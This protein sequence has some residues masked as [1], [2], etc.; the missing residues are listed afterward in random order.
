[1]VSLCHWFLCYLFL[2]PTT[3]EEASPGGG[4]LQEGRGLCALTVILN[5]RRNGHQPVVLIVGSSICEEENRTAPRMSGGGV[6]ARD[7]KKILGV[8]ALART[9]K[10]QESFKH[11][12]LVIS[13]EWVFERWLNKGRMEA[14][15]I[16]LFFFFFSKSKLWQKAP[17]WVRRDVLCCRF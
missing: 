13:H 11:F 6:W 16:C 10:N 5:N 14:S 4:G 7:G 15:E 12:P 1:M 2:P 3:L 8:Y 9:Q 17:C